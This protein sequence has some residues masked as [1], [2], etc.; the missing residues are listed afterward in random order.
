VE[1]DRERWYQQRIAELE[2]QLRQ[3]DERIAA[4]ERQVAQLAEQVAKLSKNSS[5]SSK[6]PSSDIVKPPKPSKPKGKNR[7]R[8][9]KIGGQPGH[10]KH[11]REPFGP[12]QVNRVR[13]YALPAC[14]ACG[15]HLKPVKGV[16]RVIQQVEIIERPIRITE[17]RGLRYWCPHCRKEHTAPLPRP[18]VKSG[19]AGPKLT[20][21]VA[22]LKGVC[23]ASYSTIRKYLRDVLK[24]TLSR[25]EL[26]KL[27]NK[28]SSALA[29]P[30]RALRDRLPHER[31]LNVDET[32]HKENGNTL[33][34]WCFSARWATSSAT[35]MAR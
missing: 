9:R 10:P 5:N 25:G 31:R 18:V 1:P 7:K 11:E 6:P 14:P 8:R 28:A 30:Y 13:T 2:H 33:W 27:M 24:L 17:Y 26:A 35:R 22:Y 19:L 29:G 21:L 12:D 15:G 32:G 16:A 4:L 34:T 3:R 20:A 23:H